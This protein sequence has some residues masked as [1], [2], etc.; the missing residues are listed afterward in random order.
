MIRLSMKGMA[1]YVTSGS[2]GQR[3][4]LRDFKYPDPEGHAQIVYYSEA[5]SVIVA[6]HRCRLDREWLREQADRLQG[7]G[8]GNTGRAQARLLHNARAIRSYE[9]AFGGQTL[10]LNDDLSLTLVF[11]D[12]EVT[13]TPDLFAE[14]RSRRKLI[15]LDFAKEKPDDRVP[16]IITQLMYQGATQAGLDVRGSDCLYL[17]CGRGVTHKGTGVRSRLNAEIEAACA[18]IAALWPSI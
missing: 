5:R 11:G 14:D 12:V 6:F 17:E 8:M 2:A 3:K 13:V 10:V 4:V 18:N 7:L 15:K 1:K 16:K 9:R